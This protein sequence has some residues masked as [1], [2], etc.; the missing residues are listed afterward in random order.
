MRKCLMKNKGQIGL[1]G[2][3]IVMSVS[4]MGCEP[5]R[6]KFVRQKKK[7]Q[8]QEFVPILEPFD[9]GAKADN[10]IEEYEQYYTMWRMWDKEMM[11]DI[12]KTTNDKRLIYLLGEMISNLEKMLPFLNENKLTELTERITELNKIMLE[13]DRPAAMRNYPRIKNEL[14]SNA[15]KIR[16]GFNLKEISES[17]LK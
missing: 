13:F 6:K 2:L 3:L 9:Y 1:I 7:E 14:A 16:L 5:F 8:V 4:S 11:V 10:P 17:I 12:N 15:K